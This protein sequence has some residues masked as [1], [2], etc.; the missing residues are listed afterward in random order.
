MA[1]EGKSAD[2]QEAFGR[3]DRG[4]CCQ[5]KIIP[6]IDRMRILIILSTHEM[7]PINL[8]NIQRLDDY[9]KDLSKAHTVEY[10]G[11]SSKDDF[12]NY[13]H[14]LSFK[15][16]MVNPKMQ[17]SKMCD[18]ITEYR[19]RLDYDWFVKTRPEIKLLQPLS[20][21][22]AET[23]IHARARMY[24]GPQ[25]IKYA[26]SLMGGDESYKQYRTEEQEL[27]LDDQIYI[28]HR[29]VVDKNGFTPF[30]Q[31]RREDEWLHTNLWSQRGIRRNMIG[32]HVAFTK[33]SIES[34]CISSDVNI[35]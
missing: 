8:P 33:Y 14:I 23:T 28:F 3:N 26:S 6:A 4:D 27:V 5:F 24:K 34:P 35:V 12:K 17:L 21:D 1:G 31:G 16:K 11:I 25:R 19:D 7:D 9:V 30:Q 29:S 18:F 32:L 22:L 2:F 10:A 13:E 20:F 15:Y